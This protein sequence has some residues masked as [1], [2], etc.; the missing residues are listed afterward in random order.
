MCFARSASGSP[1]WRVSAGTLR[2]K[3]GAVRSEHA[4]AALKGSGTMTHENATLKAYEDKISNQVRDVRT[5]LEEVESKAKEQKAQTEIATINRLKSAKE[6][7]DRKLQTLKTT[8]DANV[9][10]AKADIDAE[11]AKLKSS[12]DELATKFKMHVTK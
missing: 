6:N 1:H 7:I 12:V 3:R 4:H 2:A 11:V 10:Q 9:A 5:K 8:H